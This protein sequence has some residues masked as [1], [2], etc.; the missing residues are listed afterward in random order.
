MN[1]GTLIWIL[2][3]LLIAVG[4]GLVFGIVLDDTMW[5]VVVGVIIGGGLA[6]VWRN[7]RYEKISKERKQLF[8]LLLIMGMLISISGLILTLLLVY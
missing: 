7:K 2:R 3:S 6:V 4:C 5:G 1:L 8:V